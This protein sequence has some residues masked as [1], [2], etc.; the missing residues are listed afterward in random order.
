MGITGASAQSFSDLYTVSYEG[1]TI[2]NGG[3][4]E[5]AEYDEDAG[6]FHCDFDIVLKG[7][8]SSA[9][10]TYLCDYT[11]LPTYE[12]AVGN[13]IEWG[14]PSV[15][16]DAGSFGRFCVP[17]QDPI[18]STYDLKTTDPIQIQFH[19]LADPNE[20]FGPDFN[21]MDPSTWPKPFKPSLT[22]HYLFTLSAV[23]D[24]KPASDTFTINVLIGENALAVDAIGADT[25]SPAVYY[26]LQGRR[27]ANPAQ[28]Q[29]VIE[30]KGGKAVKK[31]VR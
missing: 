27:V 25:D 11:T 22:S 17:N 1:K 23:V 5:S 28:G 31:I 30:R 2:E 19:V 20:E 12:M 21:P 6:W 14:T 4:I 26:D 10:V 13:S 7:N 15:C 3:Y 8:H 24:G 29:L 18:V 16:Y 9:S